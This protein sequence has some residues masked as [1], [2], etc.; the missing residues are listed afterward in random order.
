MNIIV[1]GHLIDT[2]DIWDITL[3]SNSREASVTIQLIGKE[4]ICI[5]RKIPYDS[6]GSDV[7]EYCRPYD[8]LY[9][10]VKAE[11]EKDKTD[12]PTFKI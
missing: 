2:K 4:P 11:W 10:K 6:T 5:Y 1:Q 9:K 12:I 3:V 7:R 8:E